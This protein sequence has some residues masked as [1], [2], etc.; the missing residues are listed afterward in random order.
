MN[1]HQIML[2]MIRSRKIKVNYCLLHWLW[3]FMIMFMRLRLIN[4]ILM[5]LQ[6]CVLSCYFVNIIIFLLNWHWR[7]HFIIIIDG[8][9]H[10]TINAVHRKEALHTTCVSTEALD[11]FTGFTLFT[12]ASRWCRSIILETISKQQVTPI[13]PGLLGLGHLQTSFVNSSW[14]LYFTS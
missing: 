4:S 9:C 13:M 11:E 7:L 8:H 3:L 2:D 12:L 14:K 1:W 6:F 10:S 5:L